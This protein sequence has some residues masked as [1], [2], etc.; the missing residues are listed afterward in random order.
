MKV[1]YEEQLAY[2]AK[3]KEYSDNEIEELKWSVDKVRE[4][5]E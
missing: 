1:Y 3:S 5:Q 2:L 4:Q